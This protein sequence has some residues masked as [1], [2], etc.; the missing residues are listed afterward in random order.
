MDF[1]GLN[2][3]MAGLKTTAEALKELGLDDSVQNE[4]IRLAFRQR[5]KQA[6]PDLNGG[7]D[8]RLRR[9]ILA[10]DLLISRTSSS[11]ESTDS[12]QDFNIG[13]ALSDNAYPLTISLNQALFGGIATTDVPALEFP[14][15]DAPLTSLVQTRVL[16]ITLP[17]GLRDGASIPLSCD[18]AQGHRLFKIHIETDSDC[19]VWGDDIWMTT[20]LENRLF[21]SGGQTAIDTPR[22]SRQINI[23]AGTLK[24]AGLCLKGMGL[25][26]TGTHTAG[27]LHIRL[28]ACADIMRPADHV[29]T[30]FRLRWA[31]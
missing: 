20:Q 1:G 18:T 25:P 13:Q 23:E 28:E 12:H 17:A 11:S 10:R 2:F 8:A 3:K 6:H 4:A 21:R 30:E 5:L 27:D 26:S 22:G 16:H 15:A 31:S 14:Q 19:R 9:L 7:T 24:G 29:L